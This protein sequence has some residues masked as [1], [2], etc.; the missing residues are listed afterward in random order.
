MRSVQCTARQPG[1]S[2]VVIQATIPNTYVYNQSVVTT[3]LRTWYVVFTSLLAKPPNHPYTFPLTSLLLQTPTT[4]L[5]LQIHNKIKRLLHIVRPKCVV[6]STP[7]VQY[8]TCTTPP[9]LSL[10]WHLISCQL[11]G[12]GYI[13]SCVWTEELV[14]NVLKVVLPLPFHSAMSISGSQPWMAGSQ[15]AGHV[16]GK[17]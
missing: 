15:K 3:K 16:W 12:L 11:L 8:F 5:H 6:T 1:S 17:G 14:L 9:S 10:K 2:L 13:T 7:S 4:S